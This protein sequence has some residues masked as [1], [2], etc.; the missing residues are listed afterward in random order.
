MK[1]ANKR[2]T[3]EDL[4][5]TLDKL[6]I[7]S[8]AKNWK[9]YK[10]HEHATLQPERPGKDFTSEDFQWSGKLLKSLD[11]KTPLFIDDPSMLDK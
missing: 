6:V 5:E 3:L 10:P 11:P 8:K 9:Y 2:T 1:E 4:G 7:D